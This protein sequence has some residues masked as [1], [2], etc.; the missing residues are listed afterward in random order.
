MRNF[1]RLEHAGHFDLVAFLQKLQSLPD[2]D[3]QVVLSNA[4]TDLYTLYFLLLALLVLSLLPFEVFQL[5]VVGNANHR[6]LGAGVDHDEVQPFIARLIKS[7]SALHDADLLVICADDAD[8]SVLEQSLVDFG[9]GLGAWWSSESAYVC[10]P[11]SPF[12]SGAYF[13]V[14]RSIGET[15]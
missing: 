7:L 15:A 12:I 13:K 9:P 5:A 1:A 4:R 2:S 3:V 6:G 8:V 14:Y 10:S 11:Y